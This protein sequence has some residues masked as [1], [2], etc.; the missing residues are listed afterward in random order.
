M[1]LEQ[2]QGQNEFAP[3][4]LN[5]KALPCYPP[6]GFVDAFARFLGIG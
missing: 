6:L 2:F 4:L 3:S 5:D 1:F